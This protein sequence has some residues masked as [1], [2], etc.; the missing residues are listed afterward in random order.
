MLLIEKSVLHINL[1][2]PGARNNKQIVK[3][4][5]VP[6]SLHNGSYWLR[7]RKWF[8]KQIDGSLVE[9]E[10]Y[11]LLVDGGYLRWPSLICPIKYDTSRKVRT[12]A[13]DLKSVRKDVECCF[14]S[15]KK[16]FKCLKAWSE[17]HDLCNIDNQF[18]VCCMIHDMLLKYDEYKDEDYEPK[19]HKKGLKPPGLFLTEYDE[20]E[21]LKALGYKELK[22]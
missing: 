15:L 20:T 14:G 2:Y 1:G 11:W 12:L 4:D 9:H 19:I 17:L 8:W 13:K 6:K 21:T 7:Y 3:E 10:G 16:R 5:L 22:I 18:V